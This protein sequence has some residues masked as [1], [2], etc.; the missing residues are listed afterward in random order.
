[1]FAQGVAS[2]RQGDVNA[3]LRAYSELMSQYP[4]SPLAENAAV[5]RVR[6]LTASQPVRARE[7]ATRYLRRYPRGFAVAEMRRIAEEH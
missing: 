2:R 5:E 6:L 1:L 3:A 7:E 4:S